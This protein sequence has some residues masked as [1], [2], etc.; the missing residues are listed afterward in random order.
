MPRILL[1]LLA[2]LSVFSGAGAAVAQDSFQTQVRPTEPQTPEQERAGFHLPPGFEISLFA[3]EPEIHKPLNMAFDARGRLWLTD[4]VEYPH[5]APAGRKG[6]DTIKI[7]QDTN[8]DGRADKIS[9]FVDGLNIPIGL[10]PHAD[11]VVAFSIPNIWKFSDTN[12]DG[13]AD[14]RKV[15]FGPFG[16][17]RDTHGLNNSFRR[18]FDGW[19]YCCHGFNNHSTV[20]GADGHSITMQSG[21]TYRIRLD[22]SRIEH[23][24][25]GQVNPFGMAFDALGNIFTADCHT[26]PL[27]QLLRGGYYPSFGRTHDG[28]GFAP[29]MMD[30]LHGSTAIGG[31][32]IYTDTRFPPEFRNNTFGGNVMTSRVNRDRLEVHGSTLLAISEPDFIV[33]DDPWF[34]PVDIQ[35]GPDGAMYVADF[36]NKIIGHY[37]V[38][39]DHPGRDRRRGRIWRIVYT[40]KHA[41]TPRTV[42]PPSLA[43]ANIEQLIAACSHDSLLYRRRATDEL[44]DRIGA[45][46]IAPLK[47]AMNA[48]DDGR[49]WSHAVWVLH[50]LGALDASFIKRAVSSP[51]REVRVHVLKALAEQPEWSAATRKNVLARLSDDDAFVRRA[52]ADALGQHPHLSQVA[53]LLEL[54]HATPEDDT[55]LRHMARMA[56]RNQIRSAAILTDVQSRPLSAA[57]WQELAAGARSIPTA[58][59]ADFLA[60]YV[61]REAAPAAE[62]RPS[63]EHAARYCSSATLASLVAVARKRFTRQ[64]DFQAQLFQSLRTGETQRGQNASPAMQQWGVAL[65][66]QL[67]DSIGPKNRFW[68]NQAL[69]GTPDREN[70][71]AVETRKCA[72]GR[73]AQFLSTLPRGAQRTGVLRSAA[74]S[75]PRR[76]TFYL[77]G[78]GGAP[79]KPLE[80]HNFIR[81]RDAETNAILAETQPPRNDTAQQVV[82][83]LD[84][85]QNRRVYLEIVDGDAKRA[86]AWLAVGRFEPPL[87]PI[88]ALAPNTVARRESTAAALIGNLK[89]ESLKG[90][91]QAL[92]VEEPQDASVRAAAAAAWLAFEPEPRKAALIVLLREGAAADAQKIGQAILSADLAETRQALAQA[93]ATSPRRL[94]LAMAQSLANTRPGAATLF[95]LIEQG[96]ASARLLQKAS[97]L[98]RLEAGGDKQVKKKIASLTAGLPSENEKISQLLK[99]RSL[100]FVRKARSAERGAAAFKKNCAICHKLGQEGALVGPQLD[101]IGNRGLERLLE[102]LLDPNRN[103]DAAFRTSTLVLDDGR[104]V[105][106]LVRREEGAALVLVD[107]KGKEFSI[108]K[109]VVEEKIGSRLS[110][111]PENVSELLTPPELHDLL[112]FL[113]QQ[114]TAAEEKPQP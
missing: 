80:R 52:A 67:L 64:P 3:S 89:I 39:L 23:F 104:V 61:A 18:G 96:R 7:L 59:A 41:N 95:Q 28:L 36:Y 87:A 14:S 110:L 74:F 113:L 93:F 79:P 40:G 27:Y 111:M 10:Y 17:D 84:A 82:W 26:K 56:L 45:A 63:L 53:P 91:V 12:G 13:R 44:V 49:L 22:G 94:Q 98:A 8:R 16:V 58:Q 75:A 32:A 33:A 100:E 101:G 15:L 108:A 76:L 24:T 1:L 4:T 6:R 114:R 103:V 30:H 5:P 47:A 48:S 43:D 38:P 92:L 60:A 2:S 97:V 46:C 71:W 68:T 86:F 106:G 88:P 50:R 62:L 54:I 81:L 99:T 37:E 25:W 42:M 109:N 19:L 21:N 11:S 90:R 77:A 57:D 102:D 78:H 29:S 9:T 55:H 83:E 51:Q 112:A 66:T 85:H 72:D 105:S 20:A 31:V 65:A 70:P 69:A 35:I 107:N 34:R 73:E